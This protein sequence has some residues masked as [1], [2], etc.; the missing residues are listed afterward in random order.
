MILRHGATALPLPSHREVLAVPHAPAQPPDRKPLRIYHDE[1]I[2]LSVVEL[3]R[4]G[5]FA[6]GIHRGDCQTFS[7]ELVD[8][9]VSVPIS[10]QM[11]ENSGVLRVD[12]RGEVMSGMLVTCWPREQEIALVRSDAIPRRPR[13]YFVC[14]DCSRRTRRMFLPESPPGVVLQW[15]CNRCH[16][17][18]YHDHRPGHFRAGRL[19]RIDEVSMLMHDLRRFRE[20]M[21]QGLE[22]EGLEGD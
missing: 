9:G 6:P 14:P 18:S 13:W 7:E 8:W 3:A 20:V 21:L 2:W 10:T 19:E 5:W 4:A 11:H 16:A 15:S 17:I 12:G 22:L 1:C